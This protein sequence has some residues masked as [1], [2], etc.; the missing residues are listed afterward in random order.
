MQLLQELGA[1]FSQSL[2]CRTSFAKIAELGERD[3]PSIKQI[4]P[5]CLT[6][7]LVRISAIH[8]LIKQ[9]DL[10]LSCLEE[11]SQPAAGSNVSARVSAL[12]SQF[13]KGSTY[14]A[15]EMAFQVFGPLEMFNRSL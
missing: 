8:T 1:L 13:S 9:Y 15:L 10:V 6:R 4:R 2:K 7:W 3:I 14:L 12:Y 11:M 5:L